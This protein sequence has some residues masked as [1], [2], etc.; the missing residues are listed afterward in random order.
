MSLMGEIVSRTEDNTLHQSREFRLAS[1]DWTWWKLFVSFFF[2]ISAISLSTPLLTGPDEPSHTVKA[3]AVARGQFFGTV[4][5]NTD[6]GHSK[7]GSPY[8]GVQLPS[9]FASEV[10]SHA[11]CESF[12]D[13]YPASCSPSWTTSPPGLKQASTYHGRYSPIYYFPVGLPSLVFP[14]QFGLMLMRLVSAALCAVFLASAILSGIELKK[15]KSAVLSILLGITPTALILFSDVSSVGLEIATGLC[16]MASSCRLLVEPKSATSRQI[17]RVAI[18]AS[19][20]CFMRGASPVWA[21]ID[22]AIA[23]LAF[24]NLGSIR[25]I[26]TI[27][28]AKLAV[29]FTIISACTAIVWILAA[30]TL[31]LPGY[32]PP[33]SHPLMP[34]FNHEITNSF[35]HLYQQ[36][37]VYGIITNPITCVIW[38]VAVAIFLLL[39]APQ[40]RIRPALI[41]VLFLVLI[42]FLPA[43]LDLTSYREFGGQWLGRYLLPI[44]SGL[45]VIL[46]MGNK[47]SSKK[48]MLD[49]KTVFKGAVAVV[50]LADISF[51]YQILRAYV[52]GANSS[53]LFFLSP[54]WQPAI[55][56]PIS[57]IL[58]AASFVFLF[59]LSTSSKFG[60]TLEKNKDLSMSKI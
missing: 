26:L 30:Q 23:L 47:A 28:T 14:N 27:K 6:P 50:L 16:L 24:G 48:H 17:W 11:D 36:I 57:L 45:F 49:R 43:P 34:V 13:I 18:S 7:V 20:L 29:V 60:I 40:I 44:S 2:L 22:I 8:I 37:A 32:T 33:G 10:L 31:D 53:V 38:L 3:A 58:L 21:V 59:L 9:F 19:V 1:K 54:K 4:L 5:P 51:V 55:S 39:I 35:A 41:F 25:N 56:L 46:G 52:V 42:W 12:Q 15:R